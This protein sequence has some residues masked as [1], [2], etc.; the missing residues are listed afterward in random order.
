MIASVMVSRNRANMARTQGHG[1]RRPMLS[2]ACLLAVACASEDGAAAD[3]FEGELLDVLVVG[4]GRIVVNDTQPMSVDQ[5][6][7]MINERLAKAGNDPRK[8]PGVRLRYAQNLK[9]SPYPVRV[10]D[11]LRKQTEIQHVELALPD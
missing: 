5:L 8:Q 4:P 2:L 7:S 11:A 3:T 10:F 9:D 1:S 6:V